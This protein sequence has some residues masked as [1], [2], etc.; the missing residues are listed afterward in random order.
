MKKGSI[1][2]EIVGENSLTYNGKVYLPGEKIELPSEEFIKFSR[3]KTLKK[4]LKKV[5]KAVKESETSNITSEVD[6][7][8]EQPK[9]AGKKAENKK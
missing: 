7:T 8:T 9:E 1:L 3:N 4:M 5:T 6:E 2:V